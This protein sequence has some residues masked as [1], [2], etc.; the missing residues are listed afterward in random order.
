[1]A[2]KNAPTVKVGIR[3]PRAIV[4]EIER[5]RKRDYKKLSTWC[6][7]TVIKQVKLLTGRP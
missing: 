7:E 2:T 3:L 4:V 6:A 1:M 5:L